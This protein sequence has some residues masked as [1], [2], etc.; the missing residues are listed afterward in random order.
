MMTSYS[1]C[2]GSVDPKTIFSLLLNFWIILSI[3]GANF[4]HISEF[5]EQTN[6][7]IDLSCDM[8]Y[9]KFLSTIYL[10]SVSFSTGRSSEI[11]KLLCFPFFQSLMNFL[12]SIGFIFSSLYLSISKAEFGLAVV[13]SI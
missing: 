13:I 10:R 8:K 11:K 4:E 7:T 5:L 9:L 12:I 1:L 6:R 3:R 2:P